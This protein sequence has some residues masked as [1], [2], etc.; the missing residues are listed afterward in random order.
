MPGVSAGLERHEWRK[1]GTCSGLSAEA[2]FAS[3]LDLTERAAGALAPGLRAAAGRSVNAATLRAE[4]AKN[5]PEL[6][7]S[8]LFV[9][10]NLRTRRAEQQ[11]RP[12]LIEVRVCADND[13]PA[14]APGKLLACTSVQRRDQ[15]CGASFWIDD[16]N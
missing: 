2:Y 13:G 10:K 7:D 6:A 14:G 4:V 16:I 8:L 1:H 9:C 12:Y 5:D 11:R 3:A 15:G